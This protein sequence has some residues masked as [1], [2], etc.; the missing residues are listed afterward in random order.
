MVFYFREKTTVYIWIPFVP[1]S[2]GVLSRR[3]EKKE[4][5]AI[6]IT[7]AISYAKE[8]GRRGE[9]SPE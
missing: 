7:R 1:I 6:A 9:D 3:E 8:H 5:T 2:S 4:E